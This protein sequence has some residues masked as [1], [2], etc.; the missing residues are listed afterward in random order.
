MGLYC[1]TNCTREEMWLYED[2]SKIIDQCFQGFDYGEA[3]IPKR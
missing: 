2:L 3:S 1:E